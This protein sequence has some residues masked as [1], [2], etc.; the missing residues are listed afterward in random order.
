MP[1]IVSIVSYKF[2]PAKVGGQKGIALFNKYFSRHLQLVCVTTKNNA[3]AEAEGYEVLPL[4]STSPLRYINPLYFFTIRKLL[5]KYGATHLLIEHPYY[6]WLG[7]LLKKFTRIKLIV[8]SH[9]IEGTRWKSLGKWWWKILWQYEKFTHRRADFNFFI[10]QQDLDYAVR[11][12]RLDPARCMVMTYGI[13]RSSPPSKEERLSARNQ[14]KALH[15][16]DEGK[17]ILLFN[18]AFDYKPNIEA[19]NILIHQ[20][21]PLLAANQGIKYILVICGRNIPADIS[22]GSFPNVI[23]AGFVNDIDIYFKAADVFVNPVMEGGGIKTKL[24]EALGHNCNA[25]STT[26]GAIGVDPAICQGKLLLAPDNDWLMFS[27]KVVEAVSIHADISSS[28]Y[29]H[30]YWGYSTKRAAAFIE[31]EKP[32]EGG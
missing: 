5:R 2:L 16:I 19:L 6:G 25:V 9:N 27:K 29:E 24:V 12:F 11:E 15:G 18:G 8:H 21:N 3:V 17:K 28:Y 13:E 22:N 31:N 32:P 4:L 10:Q 23:I 1:V 20:I 26:T 14:V 7:F 30:F